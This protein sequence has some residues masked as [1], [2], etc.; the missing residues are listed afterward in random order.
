MLKTPTTCDRCA[1]S[2]RF[3]HLCTERQCDECELHVD[4]GNTFVHC[5][6]KCSTIDFYED[7]PYYKSPIEAL[8]G[9]PKYCVINQDGS[10]EGQF[11]KSLDEAM[12]IISH[13]PGSMLFELKEVKL[14]D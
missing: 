2:S 7:C 8:E 13:N 1:Y 10:Y 14:E 3:G 6:C 11:C 4:C 5:R 9:E 12:D